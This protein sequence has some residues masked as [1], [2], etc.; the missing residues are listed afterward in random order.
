MKYVAD[1]GTVFSTEAECLAYENNPYNSLEKFIHLNITKSY[2]DDAGFSIIEEYDV[3]KFIVY[4][5]DEI[6]K[7]LNEPKQGEPSEWISNIGHSREWHP[8]TLKG[9]TKI[10]VT[11]RGGEVGIGR[12]EYLESNWKETDKSDGDIVAYRIL[13]D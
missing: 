8:K 6:N 4:N 12:A 2:N 11:F 1:D 9:N 7:I 13:K 10:E 3:M 5:L